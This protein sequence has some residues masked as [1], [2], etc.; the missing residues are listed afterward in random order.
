VVV[1]VEVCTGVGTTVDV[2]VGV[3]LGVG[4]RLGVAVM[5]A[6]GVGVAVVVGVTVGVEVTVGSGV[7]PFKQKAPRPWVP[8]MMVPV[9][10]CS[11]S[12]IGTAGITPRFNAAQCAPLSVLR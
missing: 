7:G 5:V 8:I 9:S 6:D 12:D 10:D 2:D 1:G 3:A 11:I 4:V